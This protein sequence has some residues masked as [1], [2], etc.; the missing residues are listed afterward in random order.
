[1]NIG[2]E[3][4]LL[5]ERLKNLGVGI[6]HGKVWNLLCAMEKSESNYDYTGEP[7]FD[8]SEWVEMF[9]R[10]FMPREDFVRLLKENPLYRWPEQYNPEVVAEIQKLHEER[11]LNKEKHIKEL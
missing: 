5:Q 11:I 10:M 7:L 4:K 1:M 8:D 6:D 3:I 2:E 9:S